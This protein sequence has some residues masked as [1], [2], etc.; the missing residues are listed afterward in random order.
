MFG[1]T[2]ARPLSEESFARQEARFRTPFSMIQLAI[3]DR[4][5]PGAALVVTRENETVACRG[6]GQF[7]YDSGSPQVEADTVFD[8]ASL[9]KPVATTSMAMLL[10]ERG[11]LDL[12]SPLVVILP[13]LQPSGDG[14]QQ[15]TIRMLLTHSSGLPAHARLFDTARGASVIQ[16]A[17]SLPLEANPGTRPTYSDI[18][19]ILLGRALEHLAGENLASFCRREIFGP[20]GMTHSMFTPPA[21]IRPSIPPAQDDRVFRKKII[22]GEVDDENAWAMGGVAGHA[23]LFSNARDLAVFANCMLNGGQPVLQRHTVELFTKKQNLPQGSSWALGWDTPTNPSQSGRFFS[24]ASY[25]HLGF[26]GTSLWID[27]QRQLAVVFLTNRTWPDRRSKA[28]KQFR[29]KLHDAIVE[30]LSLA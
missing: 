25:G 14:H 29:P 13:E 22:Q 7:T 23:G 10:Y 5:F 1:L 27:P 19:F 6:F 3:A 26:T 20:I 17:W 28:I 24:S 15:I 2:P 18:G 12:D 16:T 11:L 4:A 8:V 21:D 9:T 30:A